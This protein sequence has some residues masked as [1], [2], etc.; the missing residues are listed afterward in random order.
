MQSK[1]HDVPWTSVQEENVAAW[2]GRCRPHIDLSSGAPPRQ[3]G[4]IS[5]TI[6]IIRDGGR[7]FDVVFP[8]YTGVNPALHRFLA[9]G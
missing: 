2:P 7:S 1:R 3:S 9:A 4:F 8:C 5:L 6:T